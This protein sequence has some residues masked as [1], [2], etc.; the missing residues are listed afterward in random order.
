MHSEV[1]DPPTP[2]EAAAADHI[3]DEGRESSGLSTEEDGD[4]MTDTTEGHTDGEEDGE[5]AGGGGG[6][7][8]DEQ[9]KT[10]HSLHW[11]HIINLSP[12]CLDLDYGRPF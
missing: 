6:G 12:A 10:A 9:A 8:D 5:G 1:T 7:G 3:D 2:R 11:K 4:E